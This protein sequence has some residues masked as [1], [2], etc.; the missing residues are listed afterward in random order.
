MAEQLA[1]VVEDVARVAEL[2][3]GAA[4]ASGRANSVA[5]KV[6]RGGAAAAHLKSSASMIA[7]DVGRGT[8][9]QE[10]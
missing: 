8:D 4:V 5:K 2:E 6:H 1:V 3:A 7:G 10:K 9:G